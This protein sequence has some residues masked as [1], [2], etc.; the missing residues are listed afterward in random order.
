KV[1][2]NLGGGDELTYDTGAKTSTGT[3]YYALPGG[4]TLVRQGPTRLTYQLADQHGTGTLSIDS[5]TTDVNRR[6]TDPFGVLRGSGSG[7]SWAGDKGFVNGLKDD[8][9]GFTNLGARQYQPGTGR[10]LSPDPLMLADNPQQWNAYAYSNNDPVNNTDPTGMALEECASGFAK[11]SNMGTVVDTT[12]DG[13]NYQRIVDEIKRA[14]PIRRAGYVKFVERSLSKPLPNPNREK[15]VPTAPAGPGGV[16]VGHSTREVSHD[17]QPTVDY[18]VGTDFGSAESLDPVVLGI[19]TTEAT[20][21]SKQVTK[22]NTFSHSNK[23][24]GSVKFKIGGVEIGA[25]TEANWEWGSE[26]TT[27]T[28]EGKTDSVTVDQ[29]VTLRPTVLHQL[30]G[31]SPIVTRRLYE[32]TYYYDDGRT[33]TKT[34]GTVYV[35]S[36]TPVLYQPGA[37]VQDVKEP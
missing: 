16:I 36:W 32:T 4:V 21:L 5:A 25:D 11:C 19:S 24:D 33:A 1:T 23:V 15:K 29:K 9:T 13:P 7:T 14:E 2:V 35:S 17:A 10:F 20:Q 6:W 28:T 8:A 22:K 31:K 27:Q 37:Q 3:R 18:S 12:Q 34:W 30:Y 26:D